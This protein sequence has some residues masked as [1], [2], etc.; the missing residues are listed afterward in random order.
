MAPRVP[1]PRT[2][3]RC[4]HDG[5]GRPGPGRRAVRFHFPLRRETLCGTAGRARERGAASP[6]VPERIHPMMF[7]RGRRTG[8][9]VVAMALALLLGFG[10]ARGL[11]ATDE[12]M[13]HLHLFGEVLNAVQ[14]NY[15]EEPDSEKLMRGAIDGMLKTLD[16][17]SVFVPPQ[18]AERMDENFRGEYSGIGIQFELRDNAIVVI[19]PLEGTPAFRLGLRAGDRITEVNGEPLARGITNE[20][21]FKLLRGPAGTQCRGHHR[22]RGGA[23]AAPG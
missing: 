17:H 22:A 8:P 19:S 14:R 2:G 21:V 23:G 1:R 15:V 4:G 11:H 9:L 16:P 6:A 7:M 3:A 20:D 12:L 18:R 13:T 5:R 10:L